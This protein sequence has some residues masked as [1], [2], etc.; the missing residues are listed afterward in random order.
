MGM[1]RQN[2]EAIA[3]IRLVIFDFD[4]T[5]I[6]AT[7]AICHSF[8]ASL[9]QHGSDPMSRDEITSL[10][11]RPLRAM[12]ATVLPGADDRAVQ[13]HVDAY[14]EAF[15]PISYSMTRP[16]PGMR[17][18]LAALRP[19]FRLAI[20]T[21]RTVHGVKLI[22]EGHG[23]E[24]SFDVIVGVDTVQKTKPDPAPLLHIT[25]QL[26]CQPKETIMVGDTVEDMRA[27]V[28]AGI[29]AVGVTTGFSSADVLKAAGAAIIISSLFDLL[30]ML[31]PHK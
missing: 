1:P 28:A 27:A 10:I 17:E 16:L 22:L 15:N 19:T 4:N 30:P 31:L 6:D 11:G 8:N 29:H 25:E 20:A 9:T 12:F 2:S 3:G 21:N 26:S 13:K 18:C 23:I 7:D 5:L 14:R 24:E